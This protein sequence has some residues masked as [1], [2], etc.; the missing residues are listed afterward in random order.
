M[1]LKKRIE[2]DENAW[3]C[4]KQKDIKHL[5]AITRKTVFNWTKYGCPVNDDKSFDL[6]SVIKWRESRIE[7]KKEDTDKV[8]LDKQKLVKQIR[9][10]ELEIADKEKKTIS[11]EKF[12]EIQR[13]QATELMDFVKGGFKRNSLK[14]ISELGLSAAALVKFNDVM[15]GFMKQM[16]DAFIKSGKELD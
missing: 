10:L 3:K 6:R 12:E 13:K 11:R 4:L 16:F 9:K 14:I 2:M 7:E 5:F 1:S 15:D 8:D